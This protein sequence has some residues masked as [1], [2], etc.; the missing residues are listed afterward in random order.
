M[1]FQSLRPSLQEVLD[2]LEPQWVEGLQHFADLEK[3]DQLLKVQP[4]HESRIVRL[5]AKL[6]WV[7]RFMRSIPNPESHPQE[8]RDTL[9][10]LCVFWAVICGEKWGLE[11]TLLD[12]TC[13]EDAY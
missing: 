13:F 9:D 5:E 11:D 10:D 7:R 12:L 1:S 8:A 2:R 3:E 6:D 4:S